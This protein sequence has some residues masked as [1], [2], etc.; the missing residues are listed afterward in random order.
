[1]DVGQRFCESLVREVTS[2]GVQIG[3]LTINSNGVRRWRETVG[4]ARYEGLSIGEIMHYDWGFRRD[5]DLTVPSQSHYLKLLPM[6]EPYVRAVIGDVPDWQKTLFDDLTDNGTRITYEPLPPKEGV[7]RIGISG[8][9]F[10]SEAG[11]DARREGDSL[12]VFRVE[13]ATRRF[14]SRVPSHHNA[15][16]LILTTQANAPILDPLPKGMLEI[17]ERTGSELL[18]AQKPLVSSTK[19]PALSQELLVILRSSTLDLRKSWLPI[20]VEDRQ[21]SASFIEAFRKPWVKFQLDR[22]CHLTT[23]QE[24]LVKQV[25]TTELGRE[26][27]K[28]LLSNF[29]IEMLNAFATKSSPDVVL[30]LLRSLAVLP[31]FSSFRSAVWTAME[32]SL[33]RD[34]VLRDIFQGAERLRLMVDTSEEAIWSRAVL[35]VLEG[36]PEDLVFKQI[37]DGCRGQLYPLRYV[38]DWVTQNLTFDSIPQRAKTDTG[39]LTDHSPAGPAST[40]SGA[41]QPTSLS[42]GDSDSR[43]TAFRE[44]LLRLQGID[45]GSVAL[46]CQEVNRRLEGIARL[47]SKS[48]SIPSIVELRR[49]LEDLNSKTNDWIP[50]L[51]DPSRLQNDYGDASVAYDKAVPLIG[52]AIDD[53]LSRAALTPSDLISVVG[54]IQE[55]SH[56]SDLPD[57]VWERTDSDGIHPHE[58]AVDQFKSLIDPQVR[59]R[60]Q[61][62]VN[63]AN[64][65]HSRGAWLMPLIPPVGPGADSA[66][67]EV[68]VR[69]YLAN[70]LELVRPLTENVR[71][72]LAAAH[73]RTDI[74]GK[75]RQCVGLCNQLRERVS[76][77]VL[78]DAV[79]RLLEADS[80][81]GAALLCETIERTVEVLETTLGSALD[82]SFAQLERAMGR[83]SRSVAPRVVTPEPVELWI[84]HN[85]VDY[86]AKRVPLILV[87]HGSLRYGH[88]SAPL[89]LYSRYRISCA[90]SLECE[91]TSGHR[92]GWPSEWP[93]VSPAELL[94]RGDQWRE[95]AEQPGRYQFTFGI[96]IPC[97]EKGKRADFQIVLRGRSHDPLQP[98]S[99]AASTLQWDGITKSWSPVQMHW[100]NTVDPKQVEQHPIGP[101]R[102]AES[103]LQQIDGSGSF[104]VI[105]PR[106]FGKSTLVEFLLRRAEERGFVTTPAVVCT[107]HRSGHVFDFEG[108]WSFI[109]EELQQRLDAAISGRV[110]PE[111][112][113]AEAAFDSLRKQAKRQGKRGILVIF[114][115]AQLFFPERSGHELANVLKDRLE[116]HWSAT[117]DS[118]VP[119]TLGFA[120]LPSLTERMGGNFSGY[121]RKYS[122]HEFREDELNKVILAVT[123]NSL[124]TTREARRRI[125]NTAGNM[126]MVRDL[127][128]FIA[129]S[130]NG[131][132]RS[133]CGFDDVVDVEA[134]L[135]QDLREGQQADVAGYIRDILNDELSVWKPNSAL[136]LA[137][138]LAIAKSRRVPDSQLFDVARQVL[139]EWYASLATESITL[140]YDE[141]RFQEHVATL[142]ERCVL[143]DKK[144]R[145]V[146][147]ESWLLGYDQTKDPEEW[148][149]LLF[150]AAVK[151]IRIPDTLQKSSEDQGAEASVFRY[152][153]EDRA[154]AYR[155]TKL[156]TDESRRRFSE[157]RDLL[158]ALRAKVEDGGD[159]SQYMFRLEDIGL[160]A[161]DDDEAVQVYRWVDGTDLSRKLGRIP[162]PF[163]ADLGVKLARAIRFLHSANILHRDIRPGNI[164]LNEE[165][166]DPIVIDFGFARRLSVESYTR[167]QSDYSAP[168]VRCDHPSWTRSADIYALGATLR[169]VL[170]DG[171]AAG[172]VQNVLSRCLQEKPEDR[173]DAATLVS[174]FDKAANE[175]HIADRRA[176]VDLKVKRSIG[177]DREKTWYND[178][179]GKFDGRFAAAELGL[180]PDQFDRCREAANLL[181]QILEASPRSRSGPKLTLGL[182]KNAN[183]ATSDRLATEPIQFM[184]ALR[185][186]DVHGKNLR[187]VDL[188]N[189]FSFRTDSQIRDASLKAADQIGAELQVPSLPALIELLL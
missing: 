47:A 172:P 51:P 143:Q 58:S 120:G 1:M 147:L 18:G 109:S 88:V 129:E 82:V 86:P 53:I 99:L 125:A 168:E 170:D 35:A 101:Q 181:N 67:I 121:V 153:S 78:S 163:V 100:P 106:R 165:K 166:A 180:L 95:D 184:H 49:S 161:R 173:P 38:C 144:F 46:L 118:L 16:F 45:A 90:L 56:L 122:Q 87:P 25:L 84:E 132:R 27:R 34:E 154:F 54:L 187:P 169:A 107:K 126:Y 39:D 92:D 149:A 176:E 40:N 155:I 108:V 13:P 55:D 81:S 29:N 64:E 160:S 6:L 124:H 171:G 115:E 141:Q 61:C 23:R 116:R 11:F 189:K 127:V 185:N 159:G 175:L 77:L 7:P 164:I 37:I 17:P 97:R 178:T 123:D 60:V 15:T 75:I 12:F 96:E 28:R 24:S 42:Q 103:I 22:F 183:P 131:Q 57:W 135:T 138:A 136:P 52:E 156:K 177:R 79:D 76:D 134:Q 140:E 66:E 102:H 73:N 20:L 83:T 174:L 162:P 112:L 89:V 62:F 48:V 167:L 98:V 133:W 105:A 182:I 10:Y 19:L 8:D 111:G 71:S 65:F 68:H 157:T 139:R 72:R 4:Q 41:T 119:V 142:K 104:C 31:L 179:V 14:L 69:E 50:E 21:T 94:I 158:E 150:S 152:V 93:N 110:G 128:S 26:E 33:S 130:L 32:Q 74:A 3:W 148:K 30:E 151:R 2:P 36:K 9:R 63:A 188:L 117:T 114:D 146:L 5:E 186:F 85:Y 59:D 80:E 44:W 113:P 137:V 70:T 91:V 43:S 145:S